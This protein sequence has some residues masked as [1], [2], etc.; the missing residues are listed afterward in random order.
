MSIG[1]EDL[2]AQKSSLQI[3]S[4]FIWIYWPIAYPVRH[5]TV[6]QAY[7]SSNLTRSAKVEFISNVATLTLN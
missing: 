6:N 2:P 1:S 5:L 3:R 7:V 4:K